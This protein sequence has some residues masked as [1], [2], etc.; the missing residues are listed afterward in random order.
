MI[1]KK[2][3]REVKRELRELLTGLPGLKPESWLEQEASAA[4]GQPGRDA[5]T[6]NMI[7]SALGRARSRKKRSKVKS[8][9]A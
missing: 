1:G 8:P 5:E 2:K 6:L 4:A 7:R 3:L 9:S